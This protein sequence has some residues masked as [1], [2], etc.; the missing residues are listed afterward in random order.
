[1]RF[2]RHWTRSP[3]KTSFCEIIG[4]AG[5][6]TF[7]IEAAS[8]VY[9]E[10]QVGSHVFMDTEYARIRAADCTRCAEFGH[11]LFVLVSVMSVAAAGRGM[12]DS[13]RQSYKPRRGPPW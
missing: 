13:G 2:A 8:G 7:A 5:S 3:R 11:G 4:G 12:L 1:M 10:L 6:G 9:N